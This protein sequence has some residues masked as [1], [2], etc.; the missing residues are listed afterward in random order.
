MS[1]ADPSVLIVDDERVNIDLMVDLLRPRY[2]TLVATSGEQAVRRAQAEPR[3][4]ILLLD[5]MMPGMDGYEVCRR[6]KADDRTSGI[7]VIFV[8]AMSEVGDET[9]GFA[10]GAVDYITKP[11]SPPIVEAR[12]KAHLENKQARDFIVDRNR[13]LQEMV[14]ERTRELSATQDATI[15]SMATL[16]ET[17]DPETGHHLQRTQGYVR[18]LA[19]RL[20][21]VHPRHRDELDDH[22]VELLFKSA[23]LHDIG[24]VGVPDHIL[25]KPAKLTPEE[26]EE[27]KRHVIHGYEAIVATEK[28]LADAGLSPAAASFLR[29]AREIARSHHEKWDGSGYPDGL[30]GDDIP[31]SARLMAMADVYDALRSQRVYKPAYPHEEAVK[32][33]VAGRGS[34]FDPDMVDAFCSLGEEFVA[35]CRAYAE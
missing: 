24:K 28:L 15:L 6:L 29:Y 16:A 26:F 34:H 13:V 25:R 22:A 1:Q 8:T 19:V 32:Q 20:R 17:R 30:A 7:P 18:S 21:A 2:R 11:I 12:V 27:M 31:L 23:P 5:V 3:P 4:D 14:L 33:I 10:L 35:I 9:K